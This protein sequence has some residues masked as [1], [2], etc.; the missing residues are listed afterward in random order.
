[1]GEALKDFDC[2]VV[3]S[4]TKVREP[5]IDKAVEYGRLKQIIRGGVGVDNI[6]V[7]YAEEKGIAVNNTPAASSASVAECAIAHMFALARFIGISNYTMRNGEWNTKKYEG[8]E[9]AGKTLGIIG[10]GRIGRL[11]A[12]KARALGMKT[13]AYDPFPCVPEEYSVTQDELFAQSDFITLHVPGAKGAPAL[14]NAESIAKMKDGVYIINTSRGALIDE[15]ALLDALNSG[16]VAGAGLDVYQEEPTKNEALVNHANVS[17]T[18]HIGGSTKE[19]Q[20]R[21]G[22]EIVTIIANKFGLQ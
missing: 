13:I 19:A 5:I 8:I 7:K 9:L 1:M 17:V 12:E 2:L 16:K 4:A 6:D 18:P 3:R 20:G 10:Y 21:I 14:I 22:D 11:V 15:A